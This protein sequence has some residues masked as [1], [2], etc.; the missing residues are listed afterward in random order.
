MLAKSKKVT[1]AKMPKKKVVLKHLK[2]DIHESRE[3]IKKDKKL[4]SKM[5]KGGC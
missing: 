3:S 4:S 2:T 5:K 1:S